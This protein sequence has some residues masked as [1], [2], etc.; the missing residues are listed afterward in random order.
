MVEHDPYRYFRIEVKELNER[1]NQ[2]VLALE[3]SGFSPPVLEQTMRDAHT[4]KGAA[5]MVKAAAVAELAHRFEDLL[6]PHRAR[7]KGSVPPELTHALFETLDKISSALQEL[8]DDK[9]KPASF[10]TI[11]IDLDEVDGLVKQVTSTAACVFGLRRFLT[12]AIGDLDHRVHK[13]IEEIEN[14]FQDIQN[15]T[16]RLRLVPFSTI[17]PSLERATRDLAL[18]M[19]KQVLL[20]VHGADIRLD[21]H[22]LSVLQQAIV[23]LAQNSIDHGIET[24]DERIAAGKPPQGTISLEIRHQGNR[25]VVSHR[26]DG[27]GLDL[28]ALENRRAQ[29]GSAYPGGNLEDLIFEPG[30]STAGQVTEISGRGVGL[31]VVRSSVRKLGGTVRVSSKQGRGVSFEIEVPVSLSAASVLVALVAGREIM[32]P[33]DSVRATLRVA[34]SQIVSTSGRQVIF[35]QGRTIPFVPLSALLQKRARQQRERSSWSIV[36]L[37]VGD[38]DAALGVDHLLGNREAVSRPLPRLVPSTPLVSSLV[39]NAEGDPEMILDPNGLARLSDYAPDGVAAQ[40]VAPRSLRVLVIDDSMTT[41]IL[42]QQ[43]L[44]AAGFEVDLAQSAE[45]ALDKARFKDY[46]L[47]LVDVEMP[48]MSGLEFVA[49]IRKD[50][51]LKHVPAVLVTSLGSDEDKRRGM[52]VGAQGYIVKSEFSEAKLLS[53]VRGL[54][55]NI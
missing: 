37:R 48:G 46:E 13:T 52:A 18:S 1:L 27:R 3:Q 24:P 30:I 29:S 49:K 35:H 38:S 9:P 43:I 15:K 50:P 44:A 25:I 40:E 16:Q 45:E 7:H 17:V 5:R 55:G 21:G 51:K 12:E 47:F 2:N 4:L 54:A 33:L 11:R 28:A 53:M 22:V 23:H 6:A 36:I 10:E 39:L 41:R 14:G 31:N 34:T 20:K 19:S 32:I 26:D 42:E 8:L